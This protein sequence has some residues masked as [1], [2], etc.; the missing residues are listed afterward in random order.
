VGFCGRRDCPIRAVAVLPLAHSKQKTS[1]ATACPVCKVVK[2]YDRLFL[3]RPAT[4]EDAMNLLYAVKL[5][6]FP[7]HK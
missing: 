3:K 1:A 6:A 5:A 7:Q 4:G 2:Q